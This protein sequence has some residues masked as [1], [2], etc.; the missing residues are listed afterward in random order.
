MKRPGKYIALFFAVMIGALIV[1]LF[2][3]DLMP[4]SG[5]SMQPTLTDG[6]IVPVFKLAWGV[7]YPFSNRYFIRWGGP[8]EGDVIIYP[9]NGRNVIKRCVAVGG[10]PLAFSEESGYSVR[11]AGRTVPLTREQYQKLKGSTRVPDGM[12][13]ALGD[14]PRESRDSREYGFVSLDSIR[15]KALCK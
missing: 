7:P 4:V 3:F 6:M 15:G 12:V 10:A 1:K 5:P 11:A 14:N 13:F 9:W 2:A 8:R